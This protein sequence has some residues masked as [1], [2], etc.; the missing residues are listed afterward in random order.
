MKILVI[1]FLIIDDW[2][3]A[4]SFVRDLVAMADRNNRVRCIFPVIRGLPKL[5][6]NNLSMDLVHVRR[7]LPIV[8]YLWFCITALVRLVRDCRIW[9]VIVLTADVFPLALPWL[10]A[11]L[12]GH[13]QGPI[14]A[15]RE[16]SPPVEI[17]SSRRYY[18][19]VLRCLSLLLLSHF[20]NPVFAIS[21]MHAREI[22]AKFKVSPHNVHVWPSSVDTNMFDPEK[23]STDRD[24]IRRELKMADSFLLI[25]HG[26]LSD[27]RGLCELVEATRMAREQCEG[28]RLLLLGKGRAERKLRVLARSLSLDGVVLFHGPVAYSDV[29]RFIAAADAGVIPLPDHPQ[30]RYQ[31]P[32]KLL[33]YMAMGKPVVITDIAAHRWLLRNGRTAFYC[34]HGSPAEIAKAVLE[35]A[36]S[37]GVTQETDRHRIAA[38][39]SPDAIADELLRI[40]GDLIHK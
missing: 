23:H 11:G 40:F 37:K 12:L 31:T 33:E 15:V 22:I 39:F 36:R 5:D 1:W 34:G 19:P 4:A 9:D 25:Y 28:L 20:S 10:L 6:H 7:Q 2:L 24:R 29:P 32:I 3:Y 16:P 13:K 14:F 38:K 17:H 18:A 30:W 8:S 21:P 26:D 35:C 27:E